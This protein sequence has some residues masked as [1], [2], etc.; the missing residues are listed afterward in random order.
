MANIMLESMNILQIFQT[1]IH[2]RRA[3][4]AAVGEGRNDSVRLVDHV[5]AIRVAQS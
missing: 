1:D 5:E 2:V 3:L 4:L